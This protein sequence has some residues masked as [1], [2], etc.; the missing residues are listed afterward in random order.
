MTDDLFSQYPERPGW[1]RQET[2]ALAAEA[3]APKAPILRARC[4]DTIK[5]ADGGLSAD[6]VAARLE[7]SI[8]SIRPRVSE[9][10]KQGKIRKVAGARG[11]TESGNTAT[12]WEAA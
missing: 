11:R 9:L 2:S 6:D 1:K 5:A 10:A 7:V 4:L 12:L 3:M 8:L